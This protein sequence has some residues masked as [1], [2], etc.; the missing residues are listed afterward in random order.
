MSALP[1]SEPAWTDRRIERPGTAPL[2]LRL[3]GLGRCTPGTPLVLHFHAGAF[4]L[5]RKHYVLGPFDPRL[6]LAGAALLLR[7]GLMVVLN[8]LQPA[9]SPP[10]LPKSGAR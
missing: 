9:A 10:S 8:E 3:Y 7:T 6:L 2:T 1:H 5:Y 4:R